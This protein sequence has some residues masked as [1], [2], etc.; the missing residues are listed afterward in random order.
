MNGG[1]VETNLQWHY[2]SPEGAQKKKE[3]SLALQFKHKLQWWKRF[4]F[5]WK[6][7]CGGHGTIPMDHEASATCNQ[8]VQV[9]FVRP[10]SFTWGTDSL[11]LRNARVWKK[12]HFVT[13]TVSHR[14]RMKSGGKN[15]IYIFTVSH[16]NSFGSGIKLNAWYWLKLIPASFGKGR[17]HPGHPG[18]IPGLM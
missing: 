3:V 12:I 16:L 1:I 4:V 10:C 18:H 5:T 2:P 17:I 15:G 14:K 13:A 8:G 6:P 7:L 11:A 9:C